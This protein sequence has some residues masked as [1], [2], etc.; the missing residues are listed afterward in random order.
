MP[1]LLAAT[2]WRLFMLIQKRVLQ[3]AVC[4]LDLRQNHDHEG[5]HDPTTPF[6]K[7]W[8]AQSHRTGDQKAQTLQ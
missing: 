1:L 5:K 2:I 3:E 8:T 4:H 6:T 7:Q